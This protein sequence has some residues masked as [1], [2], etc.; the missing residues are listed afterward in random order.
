MGQSPTTSTE[1][2]M[3]TSSQNSDQE[4]TTSSVAT[5]T[6]AANNSSRKRRQERKG[7]K[8]KDNKTAS[9]TK[10]TALASKSRK[11]PVWI[12]DRVF[13]WKWEFPSFIEDCYE[14]IPGGEADD[15]SDFD[16]DGAL[17]DK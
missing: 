9:V 1:T 14:A 5:T 10:F 15:A 16:Q 2:V 17:I 11:G 4:Q 12:R 8:Q 7:K 6:K 13:V 3:T